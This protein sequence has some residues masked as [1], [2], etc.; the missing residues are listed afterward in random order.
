SASCPASTTTMRTANGSRFHT[1]S[2][3]QPARAAIDRVSNASCSSTWTRSPMPL[4]DLRLS[5]GCASSKR[6]AR[7]FGCNVYPA[8]F[9]C[10]S[11][12]IS[13][14]STETEYLPGGPH[15]S[16]HVPLAAY[17]P[18]RRDRLR[19][20]LDRSHGAAVPQRRLEEA[21]QRRRG[22]GNAASPEH[23]TGRL[24]GAASHFAA[25]H[26]GSG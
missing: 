22:S 9:A 3:R 14:F 18:V 25:G 17:S 24:P 2:P 16:D 23:S 11:A 5:C 20:Q 26:E 1:S 7:T 21:A 4:A 19:R 10:A 13:P 8:S 15:G 6:D 12:R